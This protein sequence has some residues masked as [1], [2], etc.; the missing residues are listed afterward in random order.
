MKFNKD[1]EVIK[2]LAEIWVE[3]YN[4]WTEKFNKGVKWQTWLS[5]RNN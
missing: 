2:K 5:R 4:D 1:I 3:D